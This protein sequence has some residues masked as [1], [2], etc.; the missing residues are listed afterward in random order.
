MAPAADAVALPLGVTS[1]VAAV[2][3]AL[4]LG[5]STRGVIETLGVRVEVN[6]PS[7]E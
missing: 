6:V 4:L 1:K 7:F 5:V 2:P 3:E